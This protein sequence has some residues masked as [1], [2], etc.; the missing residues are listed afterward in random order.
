MKHGKCARCG[1]RILV[2]MSHVEGEDMAVCWEC[3]RKL[4]AQYDAEF[5]DD[6]P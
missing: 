1:K 6:R 5:S 4:K 2:P 3:E